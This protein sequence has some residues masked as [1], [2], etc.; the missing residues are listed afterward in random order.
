MLP[1]LLVGLGVFIADYFGGKVQGIWAFR[2]LN[3]S[4]TADFG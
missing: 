4:I 3:N 1:G 2:G